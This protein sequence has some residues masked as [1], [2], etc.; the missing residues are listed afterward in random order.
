MPEATG[1]ALWID[2]LLM[3]RTGTDSI[4]EVVAFVPEEL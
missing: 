4:E 2:R 1:I 3:I